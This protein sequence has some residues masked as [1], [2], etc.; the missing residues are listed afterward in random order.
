[1]ARGRRRVMQ[2]SHRSRSS[3]PLNPVFLVL[4]RNSASAARFRA[5]S[6]TK[7]ILPFGGSTIS[8]AWRCG[9]P[10]S[11]QCDGGP[12][13]APCPPAPATAT[14]EAGDAHGGDA[15]CTKGI[16]P[17]GALLSATLGVVVFK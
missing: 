11:N 1:M 5:S 6:D 13:P 16:L 3:G 2:R 12:V 17:S 10:R 7:G 4:A 14:V 8:D 15:G 9:L